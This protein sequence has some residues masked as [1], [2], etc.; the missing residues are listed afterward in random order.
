LFSSPQPPSPAAIVSSSTVSTSHGVRQPASPFLPHHQQQHTT[1]R[2]NDNVQF[3]RLGT[4]NRGHEFLVMLDQHRFN[5]PG[6]QKD[7]WVLEEKHHTLIR[8]QFEQELH[9]LVEKQNIYCGN[10]SHPRLVALDNLKP[11]L[12]YPDWQADVTDA[13][14]MHVN[15]QETLPAFNNH[16]CSMEQKQLAFQAVS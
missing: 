2:T 11:H 16:L 15:S 9:K 4:N 10:R 7:Y 12:G 3:S 13:E 6:W 8:P 14:W 5:Y 1:V